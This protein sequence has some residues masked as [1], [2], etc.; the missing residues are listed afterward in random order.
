[1]PW[2]DKNITNA[3]LGDLGLRGYLVYL[4]VPP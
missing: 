1:M 4:W 3:A 2:T